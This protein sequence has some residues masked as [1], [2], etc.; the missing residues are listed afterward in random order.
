MM[1]LPNHRLPLLLLPLLAVST[2][3]AEPPQATLDAKHRA[4]FK[5]NCLSCINA[6]KHQGKVRVADIAF[7][8]SVAKGAELDQLG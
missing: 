7:S 1:T 8:G 4:F 3:L 5:D 6:E 2:A